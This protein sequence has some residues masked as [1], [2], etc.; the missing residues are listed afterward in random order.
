VEQCLGRIA[1]INDIDGPATV[2]LGLCAAPRGES[3][4]VQIFPSHVAFVRQLSSA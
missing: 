4:C 3:S 2:Q 1:V